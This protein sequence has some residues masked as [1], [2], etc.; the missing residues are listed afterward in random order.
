MTNLKKAGKIL[1]LGANRTGE[2]EKLP[3]ANKGSS[4]ALESTQNFQDK[5]FINIESLKEFFQ[6]IFMSIIIYIFA[7][8]V[9]QYIRCFFLI[10]NSSINSIL[11]KEI[12]AI[13]LLMIAK[14]IIL[15]KFIKS[16]IWKIIFF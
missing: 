9:Q 1:T 4:K 5:V 12:N 6:N 13:E 15:I 11:I 10:T 8:C 7:Y 16:E 3:L 14:E 2:L